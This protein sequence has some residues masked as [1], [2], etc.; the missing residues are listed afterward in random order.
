MGPFT[1]TQPAISFLWIHFNDNCQR[2]LFFTFTTAAQ[3][4]LIPFQASIVCRHFI[5]LKMSHFPG[6]YDFKDYQ[7]HQLFIYLW[8]L[9]KFPLRNDLLTIWMNL[10]HFTQFLAVQLNILRFWKQS[11]EKRY[12]KI[13]QF[14]RNVKRFCDFYFYFLASISFNIRYSFGMVRKK[15]VKTNI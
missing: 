8:S 3:I 11:V 6:N 15:F 5:R 14:H 7:L 13:G 12:L 2:H 1:R 4:A 9:C 10:Q